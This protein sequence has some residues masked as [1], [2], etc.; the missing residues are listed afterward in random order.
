MPPAVSPTQPTV[1]P[2]PDEQ[3]FRAAHDVCLKAISATFND[4]PISRLP[5]FGSFVPE[6]DG[7][8]LTLRYETMEPVVVCKIGRK[9]TRLLEFCVADS[10]N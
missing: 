7:E 8:I 1:A 10:C 4:R 6:S 5:R 2:T 3:E 9:D